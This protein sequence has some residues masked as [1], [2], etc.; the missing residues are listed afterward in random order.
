MAGGIP[1][2]AIQMSS[3]IGTTLIW[4]Q[5]WRPCL[6]TMWAKENHHPE[7]WRHLPQCAD[8][9]KK[10]TMERWLCLEEVVEMEAE[11]VT[12]MVIDGAQITQGM[13][14][15]APKEK[16]KIQRGEGLQAG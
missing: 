4:M 15:I 5:W 10:E 9:E 8:F 7:M 12:E 14:V 2:C 16:M 6:G 11:I 3:W 1:W 13:H